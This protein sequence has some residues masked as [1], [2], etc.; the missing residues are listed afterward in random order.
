LI[1]ALSKSLMLFVNTAIIFTPSITLLSMH[2]ILLH[3]KAGCA[4][5][6]T[7]QELQGHVDVETTMIYTHALNK[8]GVSASGPLDQMGDAGE[9][10]KGVANSPK[11]E[12][13]E[14]GS[15]VRV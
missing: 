15:G 7:V 2:G 10:E 3:E 12:F 5:I 14:Q 4:V 13:N 8:L 6:R 1:F 11:G 9:S